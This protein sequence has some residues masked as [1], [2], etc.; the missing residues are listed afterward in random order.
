MC[1]LIKSF[2]HDIL[3]YA[4]WTPRVKREKVNRH[5]CRTLENMRADGVIDFKQWSQ[6]DG[7]LYG[8]VQY[9]RTGRAS[10]EIENK[11]NAL[12][13]YGFIKLIIKMWLDGATCPGDAWDWLRNKGHNLDK[14]IK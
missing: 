6:W 8:I 11:I 3:A 12:S 7:I 10:V 14:L 2:S 5:L 9:I 13:G 1:V 4:E